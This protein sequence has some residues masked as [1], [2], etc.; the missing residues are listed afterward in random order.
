MKHLELVALQVDRR[1]GCLLNSP[2]WIRTPSIFAIAVIWLAKVSTLAREHVHGPLAHRVTVDWIVGLDAPIRPWPSSSP[3]EVTHAG[4]RRQTYYCNPRYGLDRGFARYEEYRENHTVSPFQA[5]PT[6]APAWGSCLAAADGLVV[7]CAPGDH[8][9][10]RPR[11][12]N[13][14]ASGLDLERPADR[15]FFVFLN[16]YDAHSPC[17]PPRGR[18]PAFGLYP[19]PRRQI[20]SMK[21]A[22]QARR[23]RP[24]PS[25]EEQVRLDQQVNAIRQD[26][27]ESSIAYLDGQIGRLFDDLQSR[28]LLE[29]TLVIVTSDHGEHFQERGFSGHGMSVYRREVHV[30]LLIFP[31][32]SV[33]VRRVVPEPVSLR[34]LPS[35]VVDLLG[36][37][38]PSPFPGRSLARFFR[39]GTTASPPADPVLSEV[40]HNPRHA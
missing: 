22:E 4:F 27:Y 15:P 9:S 23:E 37:G 16:Y 1:D 3:A 39:P 31:P 25:E 12:L 28:G 30:P 18:H 33:P 32:R 38:S 8:D 20:E 35:T 5:E 36:L 10:R 6:A 2:N 19:A 13:R 24:D 21:K 11:T 40:G 17:V 14:D 7:S 34:D 26:G 29:D